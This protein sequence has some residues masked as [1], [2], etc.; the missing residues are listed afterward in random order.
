MKVIGGISDLAVILPDGRKAVRM[1]VVYCNE[2]GH[3]C[4]EIKETIKKFC[5]IRKGIY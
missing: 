5:T 3:V 2:K 4:L 1:T